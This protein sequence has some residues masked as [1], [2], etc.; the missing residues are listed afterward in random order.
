MYVH[1]HVHVRMCTLQFIHV[2]RPLLCVWLLF[3]SGTPM[4]DVVRLTINQNP[5]TIVVVFVLSNVLF[6]L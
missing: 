6:Y 4:N 1:V 5:Q 2:V 3:L